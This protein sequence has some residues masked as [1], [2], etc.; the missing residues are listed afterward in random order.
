[1]SLLSTV[2]IRRVRSMKGTLECPFET[3]GLDMPSGS[4]RWAMHEVSGWA[5]M[6]CPSGRD[7]IRLL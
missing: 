1:M 5:R 2:Q 4:G 6:W 7:Y 3:E